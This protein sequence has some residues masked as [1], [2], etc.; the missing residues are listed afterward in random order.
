MGQYIEFVADKLILELKCPNKLFG[1]P[2]P[3]PF[4]EMI[5]MEGKTNFF[6]RRVG[7]YHSFGFNSGKINS[8]SPSS[9]SKNEKKDWTTFEFRTDLDF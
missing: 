4:M 5:S 2:N 9:G 1:T 8:S 6:E 7:E 3:F